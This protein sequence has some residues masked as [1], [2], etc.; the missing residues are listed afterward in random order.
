MQI[1][2]LY[3]ILI[4]PGLQWMCES[5]LTLADRRLWAYVE[6]LGVSVAGSSDNGM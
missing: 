5:S 4:L 2:G 6:N 1:H 3:G